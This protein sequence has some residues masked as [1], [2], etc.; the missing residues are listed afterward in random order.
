[1]QKP[2]TLSKSR[3]SR[4]AGSANPSKDILYSLYELF[5]R[6]SICLFVI[7]MPNLF[8]VIVGP[9]YCKYG[10]REH[11]AYSLSKLWYEIAD[12]FPSYPLLLLIIILLSSINFNFIFSHAVK[13]YLPT[14]YYNNENSCTPP[15]KKPPSFIMGLFLS[16]LGILKSSQNK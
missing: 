9:R 16:L 6:F 5:F 11:L 12:K 14:P 8:S 7:K 13:S 1:M 10:V 2:S 15:P 3:Y 4:Q